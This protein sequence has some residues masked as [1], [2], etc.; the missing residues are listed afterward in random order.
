[1][2]SSKNIPFGNVCS[3]HVNFE[4]AF[5]RVEFSADPC[6][7]P[8]AMWFCFRLEG[9]ELKGNKKAQLVFK[10]FQNVLGGCSEPHLSIVYRTENSDWKRL[11]AGKAEIAA[12]G[13]VSLV[14]NFDFSSEF[15]DFALCYPYGEEE[16]L[17]LL[18]GNYWTSDWIGVSQGGKEIAR[19]SNSYGNQGNDKPGIYLV[20]RQHSGETPGSW[21][22]HGFL[23]YFA[24]NKN[25][26]F[27]LW[28][29]PFANID[30]VLA[31]DYGKDNFPYDLNRAWERPAMRHETGV[32]MNDMRRWSERCKPIMSL[33]FHAPCVSEN[34]GIYSFVPKSG[35]AEKDPSSLRLAEILND[36]LRSTGL[37]SPE[38]IRSANYKS[39][40]ETSNFTRF[41]SESMGLI[42]LSFEFP[43]SFAG[44]KELSREDYMKAGAAIAEAVIKNYA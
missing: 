24:E 6:G 1:M 34:K 27:I 30:G 5:P 14:W 38:F 23:N 33:D 43:Y 19:L 41:S 7:G 31:G 21:G 39:R 2:E 37:I 18:K 44:D 3:Y 36:S 32:I 9:K 28:A 4:N 16:L 29:I 8:E 26:D 10:Y 12:D 42:S 17:P 11:G 35:D 20:A 40:W 13:Q 22:L 15:M 25:D